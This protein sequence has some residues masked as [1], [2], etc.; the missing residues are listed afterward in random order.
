MSR[1]SEKA[2]L[3]RYFEAKPI[4]CDVLLF[5]IQRNGYG[6]QKAIDALN[7][8]V[9]FA[10]IESTFH[11][12]ETE[13]YWDGERSEAERAMALR[14]SFHRIWRGECESEIESIR[15]LIMAAWREGS[16]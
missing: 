10:G 6:L 15:S 3:K 14:K 12:D 2:Y 8:A 16:K 11:Q 1:R 4:A 5:Y 9:A 7:A 13:S